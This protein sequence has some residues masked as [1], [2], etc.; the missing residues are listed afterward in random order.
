[1]S[2]L[3]GSGEFHERQANEAVIFSAEGG[4]KVA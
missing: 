4:C 3:Q 2:Q 1:M